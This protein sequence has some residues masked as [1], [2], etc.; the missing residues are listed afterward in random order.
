MADLGAAH[1]RIRLAAAQQLAE[2]HI[3]LKSERKVLE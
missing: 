1:Y 3:S 2:L